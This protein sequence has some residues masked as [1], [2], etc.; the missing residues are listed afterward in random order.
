ML[1]ALLKKAGIT[2]PGF[3]R[4]RVKWFISFSS[5]G[6]YT[7][8]IPS[9]EKA[10]SEYNFCPNLSQPE[11]V[12]G[13][14]MRSQFLIDSLQT[15]TLY[16][17]D[18]ISKDD[19][20]RYEKKHNYFCKLLSDVSAVIPSIVV[21][22]QGLSSEDVLERIRSDL[23]QLKAKGTDNATVMVDNIVFL[24]RDEWH[25]W[26]CTFRKSLPKSP[27]SDRKMV[28]LAT[29]EIVTPVSTQPKIKGLA[30]VGGLSTGDVLAGFDKEAFQSYGLE[31][32]ENAAMSEEAAT[33]Y[34][35]TLSYL[36]EKKGVRFGKNALITYWFIEAVPEQDDPLSW[37]I[38]PAEQTE[39]D[40][41]LKA[42]RLLNSI[43]EGRRSDLANNR[44]TA[45]MLS[46]AA[47]R[48]MIRE[49]MEGSFEDLVININKWFNDL[50]IVARDGTKLIKQPKFFS[51]VNAIE[52]LSKDGRILRN[53]ND[54]PASLIGDL[55][56]SA[57]AAG[58]I[59]LSAVSRAIIR[60]RSDMVSD[61]P[62]LETRFSLIKSYLIRK[63]DDD[64]KPYLNPEHP[65]PAY[66]CGRLLAVLARLQRAA[67]GDVGAGV[68]QRYY[69]AASQTP[70][71]ILGR[72]MA[73]A[74]NHL[75]KLEK[76]L[77]YWY[78]DRLAEICGHIKDAVPKILTL[79]E[80]TLF[81]L[82]YYQ[83]IAYLNVG[84]E[85]KQ[86]TA[87]DN[88]NKEKEKAI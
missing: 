24:E 83:Q 69:T 76:G 40:A 78:E 48:V 43:R 6:R 23:K 42:H 5:N 46:G 32:A 37:L 31:Q 55:W 26:W 82:G 27:V 53:I 71:L 13:K 65:H 18:N 58:P 66:Q 75:G 62:P 20:E 28:C 61:S 19:R 7:G 33:A 59:P 9:T 35:E 52:F 50:A 85:E 51:L 70:G 2:K 47:G 56:R 77:A 49:I 21:A 10:G 57:I 73:N 16:L 80:Q 14:E 34:A 3:S 74:K 8:V 81:A 68:V 84:K 41:E 25:K 45:L 67:L 63:G 44:Y 17:K 87:I 36:I 15:V 64:M 11:M 30:G 29:G 88:I 86:D 22:S 72:L 1:D 54:V 60:I 38:E 4:K 79:E 39:A 12:G